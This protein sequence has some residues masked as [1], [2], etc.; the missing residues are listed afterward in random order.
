MICLNYPKNIDLKTL[1]TK[2]IIL[3]KKQKQKMNYQQNTI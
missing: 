2:W 3:Q 1:Q